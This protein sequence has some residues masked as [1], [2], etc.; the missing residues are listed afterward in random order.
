MTLTAS[1]EAICKVC[2][3]PFIRFRSTQAVCGSRCAIKTVKAAKK[4]EAEKTRA[5]RVAL[6]SRRDWMEEAQKAV[7]AYVRARD[8]GKSCISCGAPWSETFQ[9]GHF[10]SRGARPELRFELDNIHGQDVRCNMHLSGNLLGYRKG[11]IQR[12]GMERVES[13][14]GPHPPAKW[15]VDELKAIR[16]A[17]RLLL[18]QLLEQHRDNGDA[19]SVDPPRE[20]ASPGGSSTD[21]LPHSKRASK[22][23]TAS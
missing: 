13:L 18:K 23:P 19:A 3:K 2:D 7:N 11:I 14:E 5:R 20:R 15:S 16:D 6:K 17:H 8:R 22:E 12:I 21:V 4:T 1:P 9:A 10:L